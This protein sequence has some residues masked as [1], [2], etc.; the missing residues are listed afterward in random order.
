M[1]RKD[2]EVT[3]KENIEAIFKRCRSLR[4]G[5]IADGKPYIIP[6]VFGYSWDEDG[7]FIYLHSGFKGRKAQA[8]SEGALI[9]FEMD[10]DEGL[11]GQG[12]LGN[13][14]TRA[15]SALMGEGVLEYAKNEEE[16]LEYFKNIMKHQT[17]RDE[18]SFESAYLAVTMVFRIKVDMESLSA[19]RKELS[20]S[21]HIP[22]VV[23]K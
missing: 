19:S 10:I 2:L 13:T 12:S 17:G 7:L 22:E 21:T 14:Y 1:R 15:F 5:M 18:F 8:L 11:M 4:L 16:K 23:H 20:P 3:G 6:M 9:C